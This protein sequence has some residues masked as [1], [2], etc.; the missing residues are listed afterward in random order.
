MPNPSDA[1]F[2]IIQQKT[3]KK[4]ISF[5]EYM[6]L[7]LYHPEW[8]YYCNGRAI[9]GEKGD[10]VTAPSIGQTFS[11]A[12]TLQFLQVFE[13]LE[14]PAIVEL[15]AGRGQM[16][17]GILSTLPLH[18]H[19]TVPYYILEISSHLMDVQKTAIQNLCPAALDNVH[20][21]RSLDELPQNFEGIIVGNEFLDALPVEIFKIDE[22]QKILQGQVELKEQ[23]LTLT[24]N[25]K[26]TP[27][28]IEAVQSELEELS[29]PLPPGF[30]SEINLNLNQWHQAIGQVLNKG[31]VFWVDYGFSRDEYFHEQR[32]EGTIMCHHQH[33]THSDYFHH[34]GLQD[35]T[36]HVNFSHVAQSADDNGLDV[37]GYTNQAAFLLALNI[38]NQTEAQ[39][40]KQQTL[41]SQELQVLLQPH[42]MGELFKVIALG[43]N[44]DVPLLG[45][46]LKDYMHKL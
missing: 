31:V 9:I 8:G 1:L 7:V 34:I 41:N 18:Q 33:K 42:E 23:A 45:F 6:R 14:N 5:A 39:D 17:V 40:I 25:D 12:I 11:K 29:E 30:L 2:N 46:N 44:I 26:P 20:W 21:I 38:L 3:R 36:A 22:K 43:K 37:L 13:S 28:F 10:F 35:V 15:G 24:F 27:D 19:K 16:A 32:S 4:P